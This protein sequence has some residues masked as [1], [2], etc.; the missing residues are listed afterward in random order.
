MEELNENKN[1]IVP[2]K[3]ELTKGTIRIISQKSDFEL[4]KEDTQKV[5]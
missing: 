2:K 1:H 4:K 5:E 3:K